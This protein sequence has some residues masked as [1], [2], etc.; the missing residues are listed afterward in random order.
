MK[1]SNSFTRS[2]RD[3]HGRQALSK[4]RN[5]WPRPWGSARAPIKRWVDSGTIKAVRTVGKH[6]L[7]PMSEALRV[8][9]D[10]GVDAA[11]IEVLGG[12]G[13][14]RL[15]QIDNRIRDLLYNLLV[16]SKF[17]QAKVLIQSVYAAGCGAAMLGDD[18]I[19]PV[20]E[21]IGHGWMVG[22][23]DVYQEHEASQL[24]ASAMQD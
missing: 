20:M 17:P 1:S 14:A 12:L 21:R 18:L 11:N 7:V 16:E 4:D 22:A 24:V 6:R 2:N 13:S 5:A 23:I 3:D 15:P 19:R 9:R 8:A 10:Q